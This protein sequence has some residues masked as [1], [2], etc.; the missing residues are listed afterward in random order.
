[1]SVISSEEVQHLEDML[2]KLSKLKTL[3]LKAIGWQF[4]L[5]PTIDIS[6]ESRY[7]RGEELS[8]SLV[9]ADINL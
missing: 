6:R 7:K 4:G 8:I 5:Q 2:P 1:M 3:I 9:S